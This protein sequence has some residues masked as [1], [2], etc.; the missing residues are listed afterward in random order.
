MLQKN[1]WLDG[2]IQ[3][4]GLTASSFAE[5]R[6]H[7]DD[8][9]ALTAKALGVPAADVKILYVS[10]L[11][12]FSA[13]SGITAS[14]TSSQAATKP[15]RRLGVS[16]RAAMAGGSKTAVVRQRA[17]AKYAFTVMP[18][19]EATA[20]IE[21]DFELRSS[22]R[23]V[24][25]AAQAEMVAAFAKA[26][27]FGFTTL[28]V[29]VTK[30][31]VT[32]VLTG[33]SDAACPFGCIGEDHGK[34]EGGEYRLG[35]VMPTEKKGTGAVQVKVAKKPHEE[36]PA[37]ELAPWDVPKTKKG[38]AA[39]GEGKLNALA[40]ASEILQREVAPK[41]DSSG[42][43][44]AELAQVAGVKSAKADTAAA[45][46]TGA[47][48]KS[49]AAK[50]VDNAPGWMSIT[51][52]VELFIIGALVMT[53]GVLLS[54]SDHGAK[55]FDM[56]DDAYKG[57]AQ[58]SA[59]EDPYGELHDESE[60]QGVARNDVAYYTDSDVE[61]D[62]DDD[63]PGTPRAKKGGKSGKS[64]GN[65]RGGSGGGTDWDAAMLAMDDEV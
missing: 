28:G 58:A 26:L 16:A 47:T 2:A 46:V 9:I 14:S 49:K 53:G 21:V 30:V 20:G 45:A 51:G 60:L 27:Q 31:Y 18:P 42:S 22:Q 44:G 19:W 3:L 48:D 17:P 36:I 40:D 4:D 7:E 38:G 39:A 12:E 8:F 32:N 63:P 13:T 52:L 55:I 37:G 61:G 56:V 33:A 6:V 62:D 54:K 25:M 1:F 24:V 59:N 5:E 15:P 23:G 64:G 43:E 35:T 10:D 29:K 41:K 34:G 50:A 65:D 11:A 57:Y